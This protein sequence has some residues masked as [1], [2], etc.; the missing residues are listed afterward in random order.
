MGRSSN[1]GF[2]LWMF[3]LVT[4]GAVL[5]RSLKPHSGL[6]FVIGFGL[7]G[8]LGVLHHEL[9]RDEL[10]SWMLARDS[11]SV[12]SLL[13]NMRL[14]GHP[15][16]WH[17]LL[18]GLTQISRH[19]FVMQ[20][21]N[22][23][24][25]IGT[26]YL[27]NYCSPFTTRQKFLLTF[28]YFILYEYTVISRSY[29]LGVFLAFLFCALSTRPGNRLLEKP[30]GAFLL[31]RILVLVALAN[32]SLYGLLLSVSLSIC[33]MDELGRRDICA[34][35]NQSLVARAQSAFRSPLLAV[36][37]LVSGWL[38]S[39][40]QIFR[41]VRP[42]LFNTISQVDSLIPG[43]LIQGQT[44]VAMTGYAQASLGSSLPHIAKLGHLTA[45]V[46]KSYIP[47]PQLENP[48]FWNTSF[49][50]DT[51]FLFGQLIPGL[52]GVNLGQALSVLLSI[53]LL[54]F[55]FQ[56]C[57]HNPTVKLVYVV[58]NILMFVLFYFFLPMGIRHHG[59][60]F[61]LLLL[62]IW[63]DQSLL[64][65][66]V[67]SHRKPEKLVVQ[68]FLQAVLL[69]QALVG[70]YAYSLDWRY[71]FSGAAQATQFIRSNRLD[72]LPI[73][74]MRTWQTSA[75]PGYLDRQ[76]YYPELGHWG[77][78]VVPSS[79]YPSSSESWARV[80]QL[81]STGGAKL[82]ILD[83]TTSIEQFP[84]WV[85]NLKASSPRQRI[86]VRLLGKFEGEIV[87]QET[88]FLYVVQSENLS[89]R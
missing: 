62:C 65:R 13:Y 14:E 6:I 84:T 11:T 43:N 61:I 80:R 63:L 22:L 66:D 82:V 74:G 10:Q 12:S 34:N 30:S 44:G 40:V 41:A 72:S 35:E 79:S 77:S 37:I 50:S 48:S 23:L 58:G 38:L 49:F 75:F 32:T 25:G 51:P 70:G 36:F 81:V 53:L 78:F 68:P 46:W 71:E 8:F 29:G 15:M 18:L 85:N 88:F 47:I 45:Y 89:L 52:G 83:E 31:L 56:Y 64:K 67:R 1:K 28:S 3:E 59:H 33:L 39:A 5:L 73:V 19:S 57:I 60:L 87:T 55:V 27:V 16:L 2:G 17:L 26:A 21:F 9:W 20:L 4:H 69:I 7:I 86:T 24:I 42:E 54:F 76:I